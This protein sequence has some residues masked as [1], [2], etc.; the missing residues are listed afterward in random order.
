MFHTVPDSNSRHF[1][2]VSLTPWHSFNIIFPCI[3]L[4]NSTYFKAGLQQL[5]TVILSY[6]LQ[7]LKT[8]IVSKIV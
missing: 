3:H 7:E 8:K 1:G 5:H 2:L 4:T 6:S